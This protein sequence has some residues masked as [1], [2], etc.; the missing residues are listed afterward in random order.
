MLKYK[1]ICRSD[2]KDNLSPKKYKII[3]DV[4]F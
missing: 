2:L 4:G 1:A 3:D